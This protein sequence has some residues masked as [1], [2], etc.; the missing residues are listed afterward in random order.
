MLEQFFDNPLVV[1]R[2]RA[3]PLNPHLESF[4]GSLAALGYARG[5]LQAQIRLLHRMGGWLDDQK[6]AVA[7]LEEGILDRF[8]DEQGRRG[9]GKGHR[10]TVR[11]FL[12][13]LRDVGAVTVRE[14]PTD[15]HPLAQLEG[16]YE[17]YLRTER[18][19]STD[20]VL[21]YLPFVH[22]FLLERFADAPLLL[23][24]LR[25]SDSSAFILRHTRS[26]SLGRA[27][28]MVT[29]LRSFL[30]FLLQYGELEI[31]L[32][33]SVPAVSG[34]RQTSVP[35]HLDPQDVRRLLDGCNRNT[36][37]GRR[38]YA[39]LVLLARL[40]LRAG[41]VVALQLDDVDWRAGEIK[42]RGKG[43][44][45]DRLPLLTD[46]GEALA[47]YLKVGRPRCSSRQ[48]FIRAKA[49][50]RGFLSPAAV[51][52][53]VERAVDRAGLHPPMRGAHLLRHSLA[54][55]MIR[56]GA[57]MAEIGQV[58]RHRAANT[59]EIYAKVDFE[60]LRALA[61]PWPVQEVKR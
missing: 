50:H 10:G 46:V 25:A 41:E 33:A 58:L 55:G 15:E 12:D 56:G 47:A 18:G 16:R 48:L 45:Q 34:W 52:T 43:S 57:S 24:E 39:I 6:I 20:T 5:T 9:S 23:G 31:D 2:L 49:P 11:H 27:K 1:D 61:R 60:G 54:T 42:V 53:I 4:T 7:D 28:L 8:L 35:K 36:A 21:N 19:L 13:H 30:R 3:G 37:V 44:W 51:T 38:N 14:H 32:A 59:T 29:A 22:R 26:M 40:G 17:R